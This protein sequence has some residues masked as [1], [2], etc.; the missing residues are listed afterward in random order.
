MEKY[1]VTVPTGCEFGTVI[2]ADAV[3]VAVEDDVA[4]EVGMSTLTTTLTTSMPLAR[5]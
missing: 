5:L 2:V 4:V 3:R 1:C